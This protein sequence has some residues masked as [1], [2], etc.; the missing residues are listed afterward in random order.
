MSL[1]GSSVQFELDTGA[2]MTVMPEEKFRQL[3]P[4]QPLR[5][6][7]VQLNIFTGELLKFIDAMDM[8]VSYQD[9]EPKT[10]PLVDEHGEGPIL[11]GRNRLKQFTLDW[12]QCI[13]S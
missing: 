6:S 4:D 2:V 3:F 12:S 8:E 5:R 1:K 11:L 10:L 7:T 13:R 9:Q